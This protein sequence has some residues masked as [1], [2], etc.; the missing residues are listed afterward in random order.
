MRGPTT[1]SGVTRRPRQNG[2]LRYAGPLTAYHP[3]RA[4]GRRERS[5]AAECTQMA[6]TTFGYWYR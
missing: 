3:R 4:A 5:S 2:G 1:G 6:V